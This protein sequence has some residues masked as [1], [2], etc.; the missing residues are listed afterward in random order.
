MFLS[1]RS[2]RGAAALSLRWQVVMSA[3]RLLPE[4]GTV[5]VASSPQRRPVKL[6]GSLRS[7]IG[8]SGFPSP[9]ANESPTAPQTNFAALLVGAAIVSGVIG[10]GK[11][12]RVGMTTPA[13][14]VT[15]TLG[16]RL[17]AGC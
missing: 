9:D 12:W 8:C 3:P 15:V 10:A 2:A 4:I 17:G 16:V 1:V 7:L 11:S 13:G 6:L 5:I 14:G